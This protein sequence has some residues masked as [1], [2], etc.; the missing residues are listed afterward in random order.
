M[1]VLDSFIRMMLGIQKSACHL[2]FIFVFAYSSEVLAVNPA[3]GVYAGVLL[4]GSHT[5]GHDF[6]LSDPMNFLTFLCQNLPN[7]CPNLSN[8]GRLT[9][10]YLG[11]VGL[12]LGYRI[13]R[14][15]TELEFL[16][17]DSPYKTLQIG[18]VDINQASINLD[19]LRARRAE[20][21]FSIEG[22]TA[23][24][25]GFLNGYYDLLDPGQCDHYIPYIGAG[26]G[27]ARISNRNQFF[28]QD[29]A[30]S[31]TYSSVQT[32]TG[33]AQGIL[34]ISYFFGDYTYLSLDYRYLTSLKE[35]RFALQ[36]ISFNQFNAR[37]QAHTLNLTFNGVLLGI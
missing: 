14:Y 22:K 29:V 4:G 26:I 12:Q 9:Y 24:A 32:Q 10:S 6:T 19:R 37:F 13:K 25:A 15:R 23:T 20:L 17:N 3:R 34:G 31:N 27:Y 2:F 11:G 5:P 30:I 36:G 21:E 33:V 1:W 8:Q 35:V 28:S 7:A 16:F 18:G